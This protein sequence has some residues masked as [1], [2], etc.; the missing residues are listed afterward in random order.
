MA[1]L[2][3]ASSELRGYIRDT[4]NTYV[5]HILSIVKALKPDQDMVPFATGNVSGKSE[6]EFSALEESVQPVA[7]AIMERLDF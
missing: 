7:D 2:Q 5:L 6:E 3:R 1:R 4:A